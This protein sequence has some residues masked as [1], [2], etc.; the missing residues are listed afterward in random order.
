MEDNVESLCII[1][2]NAIK[3]YCCSHFMNGSHVSFYKAELIKHNL[4]Q[5][6]ESINLLHKLTSQKDMPA[7]ANLFIK[8]KEDIYESR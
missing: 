6:E 2:D 4:I 8:I 3:M 7:L 5:I 1:C